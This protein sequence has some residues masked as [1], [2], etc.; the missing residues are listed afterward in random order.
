MA[1]ASC[2][3]ASC[4]SA[5]GPVRTLDDLPPTPFHARLAAVAAGGPFCD[6]YILGIVG[7][8]L[9]SLAQ[10]RHLSSG[11]IGLVGASALLGVLA[12]GT[13]GGVVADRL[14]RKPLFTLNIAAFVVLSL[15]QAACPD[16]ATLVLLRFLLGVAV[17][18]DYPIAT[19][20]VT[21]FMPRAWRGPILS[22]LI[23]SW[24]VG[25]TA[26]YAV[27]YLL[28][29]LGDDFWRAG[30]ASSAV[31]A[32]LLFLMRA[33]LPESPRW[34]AQQGRIEEARAVVRRHLRADL[35]LG[36]ESQGA[37][38][39]MQIL[40]SRYRGPLLFVSA[41]WILQSAPGFA[42]HTLQ[43]QLLTQYHV[44]GALL[45]SF[46]LTGLTV[47]GILPVSLGLIN[48][49][50]RRPLLMS[51]FAVSLAGLLL[52]GAAPAPA[53]WAVFLGFTLY[54]VAEAAGSG[55]QF[56]YP[57]ELFPTA[58]RATAMGLACSFS[59][60]GAAFGTFLL[61]VGYARF[62]MQAM[63]LVAAGCMLLGLL[64]SW[65]W[66]PETTG[67]RLDDTPQPPAHLAAGSLSDLPE[68]TTR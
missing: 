5:P 13:L 20:Y 25:Y 49:V 32:L 61:P 35:P 43:A 7:I 34:L 67:L 15:L 1:A 28:S 64:I 59:R 19:A 57:N 48:R 38:S 60:L 42:I 18:A 65:R 56:V 6:G 45:G 14:G 53:E 51:T 55:L 63:M 46:I 52:L 66:A 30:L 3:S 23:L 37:L 44:P 9:P 41:F 2:P 54:S 17:G 11:G 24:W 26:S 39:V 50:G 47:L 68:R 33:G 21:E 22:G 10:D 12:G 29:L 40:R 58:I 62:G 36:Q 31:P 27:G 8:A 16:L 4:P